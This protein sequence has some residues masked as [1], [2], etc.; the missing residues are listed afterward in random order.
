MRDIRFIADKR[1]YEEFVFSEIVSEPLLRE[2]PFYRRLVQFVLDA[3]APLFYRQSDPSEHANFSAYYNFILMRETY[4]N[5]T[6]RAMYFV[7]DFAHMLFYYPHDVA[8]VSRAEFEDALIASEYAASNETEI[9]VHY[10]VP[11]LRE[12]IFPD[13]RIF[14][15]LLRER[16]VAQPPVRALLHLRR[17]MI[18][19][20]VLDPFFFVDARDETV[21]ATFKSYRGNRAWCKHRLAEIRGL[22]NPAEY[23]YRF[24]TPTNYERVVAGYESTATQESYE[25][26]VLMNVRL[27]FVLLDLPQPP[28]RFGDCAAALARLEDKVLVR[29]IAPEAE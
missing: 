4:T 5:P 22:P 27:A 8:S 26:T 12:R 2:H 14:F 1:E 19:D 29:S 10:R 28:T 17:Q 25:R 16:G 23:F 7:H 3:K 6:L 18:E 24:L 9:L 15:D 21:R 20:D 11:P 13:R